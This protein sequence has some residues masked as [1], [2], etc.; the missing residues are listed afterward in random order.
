M[1]QTSE[2]GKAVYPLSTDEQIV[3]STLFFPLTIYEIL[4]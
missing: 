2:Q 1:K 3:P 4:T